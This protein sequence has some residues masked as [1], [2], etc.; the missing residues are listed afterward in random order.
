MS[1][2]ERLAGFAETSPEAVRRSIV[3]DGEYMRF[4][5]NDRRLRHGRLEV[6]SLRELR[7]RGG[8]SKG[9]T[10]VRHV[11]ANVVDLHADPSN[12]GAV[13]QV[14]SQFNLLEMA[15]PSRT[16]EHG[17]AC[18][19]DDHTQGP[20]C[21]M[22]AGAGTIYRNYFVPVEGQIGQ[23]SANQ[24][25]C[26]AE[27]GAL[28][29]NDGGRLWEMRNG[30]ALASEEGLREIGARLAKGEC[31]AI[32]EAL[33]VGVQWDAQVTI[34]GCTHTVSQ[35]YG[36]AL[37]VAY[38]RHPQALWEPF[39]RLILEA[40]YDATLSAAA[41]NASPVVYL[42]L[43]GGGAFGNAVNWIVEAMEWALR[44]HA[45]S[46]LEVAIVSYRARNAQVDAM[47]G[48]L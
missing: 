39:A 32:R 10:L 44:R 41:H 47:I 33:R 40:S 9:P 31:D 19:E 12:Q 34:D 24:I 45:R 23:S 17:L 43:L 7:A 20:A 42:T 15:H 16:P 46:G 13:F 48:R 29:G 11:V 27:V 2:F 35:V 14:A 8:V 37:P 25:D 26:L 18:Y 30:Y 21:A 1:W 38:C 6:A 4:L 5:G 22:A 3:L 28:L 36:S